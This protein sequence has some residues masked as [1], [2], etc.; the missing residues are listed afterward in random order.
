MEKKYIVKLV[1]DAYD[2]KKIVESF[3]E[4][5]KSVETQEVEKAKKEK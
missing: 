5:I 2:F 4:E 3:Y 1:V